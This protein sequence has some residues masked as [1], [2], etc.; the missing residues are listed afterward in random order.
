MHFRHSHE[1]IGNINRIRLC[2]LLT[3]RRNLSDH[4]RIYQLGMVCLMLSFALTELLRIRGYI[5]SVISACMQSSTTNVT[6]RVYSIGET[7]LGP[8]MMVIGFV[9]G[10]NYLLV[11]NY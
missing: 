8:Y 7:G 6:Q 1:S 3:K 9:I 5:R 10:C 4:N 2:Y 11:C